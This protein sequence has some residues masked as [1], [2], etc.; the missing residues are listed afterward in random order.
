MLKKH[1]SVKAGFTP[2]NI[3]VV[4]S[5][6]Q[7]IPSYLDMRFSLSSKVHIKSERYSS[8]Y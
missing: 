3:F 7:S 1:A 5:M 2:N 4:Q 6:F 8:D